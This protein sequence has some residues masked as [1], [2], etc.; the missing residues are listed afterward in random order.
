M[1]EYL[2]SKNIVSGINDEKMKKAILDCYRIK[3]EVEKKLFEIE[4]TM[5]NAKDFFASSGANDLFNS[6]EDFKGNFASVA[7]TIEIYG[8]DLTKVRNNF[9]KMVIEAADKL[10]KKEGWK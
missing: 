5:Y 10:R 7:N 6:F 2:A 8:D 3:E 1:S 9:H 4:T